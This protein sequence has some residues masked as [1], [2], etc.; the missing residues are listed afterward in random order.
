[1]QIQHRAWYGS[2]SGYIFRNEGSPTYRHFVWILRHRSLTVSSTETKICAFVNSG[3]C[4]D[5]KLSNCMGSMLSAA[6]PS[7]SENIK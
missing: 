7:A 4:K 3:C 2:H 5:C 6:L 1:M